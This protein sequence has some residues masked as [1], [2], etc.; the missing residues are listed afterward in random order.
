M[1]S[2]HLSLILLEGGF[3][4]YLGNYWGEGNLLWPTWGVCM[5]WAATH[6]MWAYIHLSV[7]NPPTVQTSFMNIHPLHKDNTE[8]YTPLWQTPPFSQTP[9]IPR[10]KHIRK[11][12]T[13]QQYK[14]L[15]TKVQTP[16]PPP[17][18]QTHT[19]QACVENRPHPTSTPTD[20]NHP[21]GIYSLKWNPVSMCH[22][23]A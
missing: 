7:G 5:A 21:C 3:F 17:P 12:Y 4:I 10:R 1:I 14:P 9:C 8:A 13:S 22:L 16:N 15:N 11:T 19:K 2:V 20:G 6:V 23:C 18:P